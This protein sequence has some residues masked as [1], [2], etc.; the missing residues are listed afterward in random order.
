MAVGS[1]KT[2]YEHICTR[3]FLV[4]LVVQQASTTKYTWHGSEAVVNRFEDHAQQD[5]ILYIVLHWLANNSV[6]YV[7]T[8]LHKMANNS[9]AA[10]HVPLRIVEIEGCGLANI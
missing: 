9:V 1:R 6:D 2:R 5:F 8:V 4:A 7:Y 10:P 3:E